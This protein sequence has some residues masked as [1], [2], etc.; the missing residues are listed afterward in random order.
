MTASENILNQEKTVALRYSEDFYQNIFENAPVALMEEDLS[1]VKISFDNLRKNGV[2]DF[3]KY[4]E[5]HPDAIMHHCS[6][7]K[8]GQRGMTLNKEYVA[9]YK[10]HSAEELESKLDDVVFTEYSLNALKEYFIALTENKMRFS[11]KAIDN[12]L[13][14]G[15]IKLRVTWTV[16]SGYEDTWGRIVVSVIPLQQMQEKIKSL[17]AYRNIVNQ[18]KNKTLRYSENF[19]QSIFDN[20]PVALMEEDFSDVKTSFDNLR[21]NGVNDFRKYFEEHPEAVMQHYQIIKYEVTLNKEYVALYKAHSAKELESKLES[22][23]LTEHSLNALKE[24]FIALT[25]NKMRFSTKTIDRDMY[26]DLVS[27]WVTWSVASG[28]EDTW[29][30]I[31]VSVIPLEQMAE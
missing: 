8:W 18:E 24:Y 4:F 27:A 10:A 23:A 28:Y 21:K 14:G 19:Y 6:L 26:G 1:D 9:L 25:E 16:A 17:P 31:V 11:I 5:E 2:H 29:G 15:S 22:I 20:A 12:D 3:R 13:C 7:M 30:R